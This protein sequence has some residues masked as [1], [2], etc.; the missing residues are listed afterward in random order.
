VYDR[1]GDELHERDSRAIEIDEA[2]L[3]SVVSGL[4]GVF[5]QMDALYLYAGERT[6]RD[7]RVFILADLVALRDIGIEIVLA[8][9]FCE[10]CKRAVY[11]DAH[12]EDMLYGL[13][14]QNRQCS[15]MTHA[16]RANIDIRPILIRVVLAWTE[17]L[18][19]GFEL[20]VDLKAYGWY[21]FHCYYYIKFVV[22]YQPRN[23]IAEPYLGSSS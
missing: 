14:V 18:G 13:K 17:H 12:L 9:P 15:R 2:L 3:M 5:F 1:L 22:N 10:V 23:L 21:I 4:S 20:S 19:G 11:S 16:D 6:A 7:E 8:I